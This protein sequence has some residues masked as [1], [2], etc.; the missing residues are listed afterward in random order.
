M[1]QSVL[2]VIDKMVNHSKFSAQINLKPEKLKIKFFG[3]IQFTKKYQILK[4][5]FSNVFSALEQ[6][7]RVSE[8][9]THL[10]CSVTVSCI[11]TQL[12]FKINYVSK[13][14]VHHKLLYRVLK[15]KNLL[16]CIHQN[17]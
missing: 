2:C 10:R 7:Y 11:G 1:Q 13:S 17:F 9:T 3:K 16:F 12:C 14:I 4:I 5:L 8:D 6:Q 15:L